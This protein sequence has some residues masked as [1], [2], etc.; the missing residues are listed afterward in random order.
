MTLEERTK[1]DPPRF[2]T[3]AC[4]REQIKG[5]FTSIN[6]LNESDW[7]DILASAQAMLDNGKEFFFEG[8]PD[9]AEEAAELAAQSVESI[10]ARI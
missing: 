2:F 9:G 5:Y 3:Q 10:R 8:I 7:D 4:Y 6:D 1:E